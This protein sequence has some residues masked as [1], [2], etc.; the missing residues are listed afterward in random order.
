M[1][2]EGVMNST[3]K[4]VAA[5][6]IFAVGFAGSGAAGLGD[7]AAAYARGDYATALRMWRPSADQGDAIAQNN[8]GVM[9]EKGRGVPQDY[10]AA[11][12]W[13]RKAADQG[14]GPSQYNLGVM[15]AHSNGVPQD[16]AAAVSWYRKAA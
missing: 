15:Y 10:A 1:I 14:Y 3:F 4:A 16:Y 2:R 6:L 9:Y 8:L 7:G 5:T 13:Y 11:V 12:S